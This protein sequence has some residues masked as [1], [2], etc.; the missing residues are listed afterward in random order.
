MQIR[1][2]VSFSCFVFFLVTCGCGPAELPFTDNS[3][4]SEAFAKTIKG[5]VL[6]TVERI[7]DSPQPADS[8][9]QVVLSLSELKDCPTGSHLATYEDMFKLSSALLKDSEKGKPTDFKPRLAEI[10]DLAKKLPGEVITNQGNQ[11]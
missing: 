3:K 9:R 7:K 10:A 1:R 4:D 5:L 8:L 6:N 2:F 11:D